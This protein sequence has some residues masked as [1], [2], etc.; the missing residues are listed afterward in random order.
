MRR[1]FSTFAHGPPGVGLL[2]MRVVAGAGLIEP[3]IR[4]LVGGTSMV[5]A[6]LDVLAIGLGLLLIAGLWTPIVSTLIAVGA[7][8]TAFSSPFPPRWILLAA[9]AAALALIGPGAWSVDA[10]WFGWRRLEIGKRDN[11]RDAKP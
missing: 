10:R 4:L 1:L 8:G 6:A 7:L 9:M 2:L 11:N 5:S 3:A